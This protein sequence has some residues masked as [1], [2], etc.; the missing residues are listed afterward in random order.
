MKYACFGYIDEESFEKVQEGEMNAMVDECF[1]YDD[2]LRKAGHFAG[3]EG[4]QSARN[5]ATLRYRNGKVVVTD[6]PF[7]E[8]KEQVGGLLFLEAKD[9]NEAIRLLSNHPGVK[10]GPWEIRPIQDL[11]PMIRA[12]EARRRSR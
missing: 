7:T 6:G 9:M 8:T 1:A 4:L 3:G 10:M 2:V 5:T 11:T 12:S